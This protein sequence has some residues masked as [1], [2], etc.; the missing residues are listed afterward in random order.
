VDGDFR[1]KTKEALMNFQR[2][3]EI[4]LVVDGIYGNQSKWV[5]NCVLAMKGI[6]AV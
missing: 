1:G 3:F 6:Q 4:Y 5:L 2:F